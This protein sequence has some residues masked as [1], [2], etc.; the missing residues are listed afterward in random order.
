VYPVLQQLED[1]N[2]ARSVQSD[3][4]K[5]MELTE[6]GQRYVEEHAEDIAAPWEAVR[7]SVDEDDMEIWDLLR[8]LFMAAVQVQQAGSATQ[9][10][11]MRRVL[12][13]T[14]RALYRILAEDDAG[15]DDLDV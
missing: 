15:E 14:R 3:K 6:E 2:L 10:E 13:D 5:V 12:A 4:R 8:Q 1:E 7:D 11:E 9:A